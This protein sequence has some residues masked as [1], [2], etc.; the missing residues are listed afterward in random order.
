MD[1]PKSGRDLLHC[2]VF[3]LKFVKNKRKGRY[4]YPN[5]GSVSFTEIQFKEEFGF[6]SN[7]YITARNRL[8]H[9]GLIKQ[10]YRGG[11]GA[12]D[13]ATYKVLI[14]PDLNPREMRWLRYPDE[15]WEHEIPRSKTRIGIK[16]RFKSKTTLKKSTLNGE[17]HP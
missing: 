3:E 16:T 17:L 9:N 13:M 6:A 7:T 2:L 4:S 10:I 5:N 15:N 12:G 1:L 8:I 11:F 14:T